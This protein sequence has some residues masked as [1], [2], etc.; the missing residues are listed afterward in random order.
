MSNLAAKTRGGPDQVLN[1]K[2]IGILKDLN[3]QLNMSVENT[4][5]TLQG[6]DIV[7]AFNT[8]RNFTRDWRTTFDDRLVNSLVNAEPQKVAS[9]LF[10]PGQI[11]GIREAK[12]A[13]GPGTF[14]KLKG[15]FVSNLFAPAGTLELS[16][17][18]ISKRW[19]KYDDAT[20]REIFNNPG[21]LK[22]VNDL[23]R[24]VETTQRAKPG[25]QGSVAIQLTQPGALLQIAGAIGATTTPFPKTAAAVILGPAVMAKVL[26]S[27]GGAKWLTEGFKAPAGSEQAARATGIIM[28]LALKDNKG[29]GPKDFK[30]LSADEAAQL[31][32]DTSK[33]RKVQGHVQKRKEG[34]PLTFQEERELDSAYP[35]ASKLNQQDL[36]P[37]SKED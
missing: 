2:E 21:E 19:A 27:P 11:E 4:G 36:F 23:V 35:G 17:T 13:M 9:T 37:N 12:K 5:K 33:L 7:Q 14:Q 29:V 28:S 34:I 3:R 31:M 30:I 15:A 22:Q 25:G 20:V 18:S 6:K 32:E 8:A 24:A 10:K 1:S 26:A 16:G